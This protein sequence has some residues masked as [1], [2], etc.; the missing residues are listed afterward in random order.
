VV[1][2]LRRAVPEDSLAVA[3]VNIRSWQAGYA[4]LMPAEILAGLRAED[5]AERYS[6]HLT[7]PND[8]ATFVAVD[9][10]QRIC[11]YVTIGPCPDDEPPNVGQL[12]AL[13]VEPDLWG[14]GVG[15]A[16]ITLARSRL[17]HQRFDEAVLWVL[18]GNERAERFYRH[19]GWVSDE[20]TRSDIVWGVR[21]V[22]KR[23]RTSL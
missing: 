15:Q 9:S 11:G 4:D 21:V 22:E 5:R 18:L 23:Y 6:F 3:Q 2:D 19:D 10:G 13:Y 16:L 20:V 8:P 17:A 12:W 14:R 1:W 7:G